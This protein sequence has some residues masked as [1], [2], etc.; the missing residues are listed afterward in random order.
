MTSVQKTQNVWVVVSPDMFNFLTYWY[1]FIY[2]E[3]QKYC[4]ETLLFI[5]F[6]DHVSYYCNYYYYKDETEGQVSCPQGQVSSRSH[7]GHVCLCV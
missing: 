4:D 5:F 3:I 6:A 2:I 7:Q 1:W